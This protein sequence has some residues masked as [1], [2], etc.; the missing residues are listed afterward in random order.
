METIAAESVYGL[1][2]MS[3]SM[4]GLHHYYDWLFEAIRPFLGSRIVEVGPGFGDLAD[5]ISASGRLYFAIDSDASVIKRLAER[6]PQD[7]ASFFVGDV[8]NSSWGERIRSFRCDTVISFNVLE[9]V[10]DDLALIRALG[11]LV[12]GGRV[13]VFRRCRSSLEA[14]IGRSGIIAGTYATD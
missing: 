12:P 14:L 1:R 8:T 6:R 13:I 10:Q 4:E 11:D 3:E 5:R 9:H 7:A 2:T